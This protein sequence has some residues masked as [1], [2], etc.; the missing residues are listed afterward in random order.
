MDPG[1]YMR[2]GRSAR[3]CGY[4]DTVRSRE[5]LLSFPDGSPVSAPGRVR[6][7]VPDDLL[8][9]TLDSR[10]FAVSLAVVDRVIRMIGI[11][12]LPRRRRA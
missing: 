9:F 6:M 7:T 5:G 1:E 12:L 2:S 3:D 4:D 8:V 10:R 11:T